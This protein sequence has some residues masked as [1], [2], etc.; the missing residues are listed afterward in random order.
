[1]VYS[2]HEDGER[3]LDF[4]CHQQADHFDPEETSIDV[5]PQKQIFVVVEG[6]TDVLVDESHKIVVLAVDVADYS[7]WIVDSDDIWFLF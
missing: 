3:V 7:D 2:Q 1:M 5:V 6:A 4:N